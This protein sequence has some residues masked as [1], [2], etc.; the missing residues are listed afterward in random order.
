MQ[1]Y[2]NGDIEMNI[3]WFS[4]EEGSY[5]NVIAAKNEEQAWELL[6]KSSPSNSEERTLMD[7]EEAQTHF[8]LNAV[9][10]IDE[11]NVGKVATIFPHEV[12][13]TIYDK[14]GSGKASKLT[15]H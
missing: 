3:Y 1:M 8:E 13:F 6:A 4:D 14:P 11:I 2:L 5:W 9:T 12:N 15:N 7:T 10:C